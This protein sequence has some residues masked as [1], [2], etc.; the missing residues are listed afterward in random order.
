MASSSD[1][2]IQVEGLRE[3]RRAVRKTGNADLRKALREA[4]KAVA[5]L[6][7]KRAKVRVPKKSRRLEKSITAR[8]SQS[9]ASV[10]AGS[11]TRVPYAGPIHFGWPARNIEPQPFLYDARDDRIRQVRQAYEENVS[12]LTEKLST[13]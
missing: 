10:K 1:P 7:A 6:V 11:P 3:L 13:E 4:H 2:A 12:K 8:G 5:T 9:S